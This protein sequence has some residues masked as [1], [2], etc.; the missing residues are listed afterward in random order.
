MFGPKTILHPTDFSDDSEG[1]FDVATSLANE[2]KA[3][4]IL[5]HVR[6][7]GISSS[8]ELLFPEPA[9]V[10]ENLLKRLCMLPTPKSIPVEHYVREGEPATEIIRLARE[11][12]TDLIVM[13]TRGRK[14]WNRLFIG[15]IAEQIVRNAPCAVATVRCGDPARKPESPELQAVCQRNSPAS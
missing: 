1:A 7:P 14:G 13:G 15:S 5:V 3:R 11:C 6:Q 4:L 9:E 10:E 12:K 2:R 8:D